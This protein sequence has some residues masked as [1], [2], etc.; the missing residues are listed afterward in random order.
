[1]FDSRFSMHPQMEVVEVEELDRVVIYQVEHSR[2]TQ[3]G[4]RR[5]LAEDTENN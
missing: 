3:D 4:I 1:M 2:E 5:N